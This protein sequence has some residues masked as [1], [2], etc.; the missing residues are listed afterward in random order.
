MRNLL[1]KGKR[2]HIF[3]PIIGEKALKIEKIM[4]K[5]SILIPIIPECNK[6]SKPCPPTFPTALSQSSLLPFNG[7]LK[8]KTS[9]LKSNQA[10]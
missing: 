7:V 10:E 6:N 4:R 8:K 2:K 5:F 1:P 3:R 9:Y